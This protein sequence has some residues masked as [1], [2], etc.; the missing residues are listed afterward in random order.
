[1]VSSLDAGHSLH[2]S[3]LSVPEGV[4]IH[5][6]PDTVVASIVIVKEADLEPQLEEGAQPEVVG[7]TPAEGAPEGEGGGGEG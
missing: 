3:D 5:D 7:E 6:N 1:D 2:V 4:E